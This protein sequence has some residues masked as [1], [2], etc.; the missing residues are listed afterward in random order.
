MSQTSPIDYDATRVARARYDLL[1]APMER[2]RF[3]TWRQRLWA[4]V[5]GP[6]VLEVGVGTG[7][8]FPYYPRDVQVTAIEFSPKMLDIARRKAEPSPDPDGGE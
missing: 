1:E 5:I 3:S 8:N 4:H 2:E 6:R 7:K